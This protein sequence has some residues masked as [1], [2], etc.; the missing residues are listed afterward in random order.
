M[1][2]VSLR[3]KI[4]TYKSK[5]KSRLKPSVPDSVR[6]VGSRGREIE[7]FQHFRR[8]CTRLRDRI[9]SMIM[10]KGRAAVFL[11]EIE[12]GSSVMNITNFTIF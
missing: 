11:S 1:D 10:S 5:Y 8:D 9:M 12:A 4:S 3:L 6:S 7:K 2:K